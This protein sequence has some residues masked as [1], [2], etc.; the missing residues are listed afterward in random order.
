MQE[1]DPCRKL[2]VLTAEGTPR[3]RELKLSWLE[4]IEEDLKNT[5][6][7]NWRLE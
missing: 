3:V 2:T 5:G 7:S 6:V 4:S 1:L